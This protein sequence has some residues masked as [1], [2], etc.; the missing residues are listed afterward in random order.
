MNFAYHKEFTSK[1]IIMLKGFPMTILENDIENS[2]NLL[3][4]NAHSELTEM[5]FIASIGGDTGISPNRVESIKNQE[6]TICIQEEKLDLFSF[7]YEKS[8]ELQKEFKERFIKELD[9]NKYK[10]FIDMILDQ[11]SDGKSKRLKGNQLTDFKKAIHVFLKNNNLRK[12]I[13][14]LTNLDNYNLTLFTEYD[15]QKIIELN[16]SMMQCV[17]EDWIEARP[18]GVQISTNNIYFRR[19]LNFELEGTTG[20]YT[21]KDYISSYTLSLSIAEQFSQTGKNQ[22]T[23]I[24]AEFGMFEDRVIFFAPFIKGMN[25]KQIEIGII[26]QFNKPLTYTYQTEIGNIKEYLLN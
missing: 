19:G 18:N 2:I 21:E 1:V 4:Q 9:E 8:E 7:F 5:R 11:W 26:P 10:Y 22:R 13:Y 24:N 6:K 23:I 16:K 25:L 14:C 15:I 20:I 17:I 3:P 12:Q